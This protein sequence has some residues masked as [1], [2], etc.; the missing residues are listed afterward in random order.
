MTNFTD[1]N[2]CFVCGSDNPLGLQLHFLHDPET[3]TIKTDVI[4]PDHFQGWSGVVHGGLVSTVLDEIMVKST[5]FE[6]Y[7]CVTA[8]IFVKFK[9]PV[10]TGNRYLAIG[11][12]SEIK[13]KLIF[14]EGQ[15]MDPDKQVVALAKA[16]FFVVNRK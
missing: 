11:R 5:A 10:L 16:K 1:N 12:I 3:K 2:Y 13:R 14:A 8:E 6:G 7:I 4:F 15:I 9:K